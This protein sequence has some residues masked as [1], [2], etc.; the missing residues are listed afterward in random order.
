MAAKLGDAAAEAAK[1]ALRM[2]SAAADAIAFMA[3]LGEELP[4]LES[5]LKTIKVIREKADTVKRNREELTALEERCTYITACV[6]EKHRR[7]PALETDVTPLKKCVEAVEA[8]A[9]L[10]GRS[11]RRGRLRRIFK[12]SDD[13]DEI[14]GLSA[15][16]DRL[17]GDLQLAGIAT[18]EGNIDNLRAFLKR[19]QESFGERLSRQPARLAKVPKGTPASKSWHVERCQVMKKAVEALTGD[20]GPRLVGLVGHS[21]SG[22]TTAASDIVRSTEVRDT[23]H[24][25]IVWLSVN[26]GAKKRL[27]SLMMQLARTVYEGIGGC[28]GCPPATSDDGVAYIRQKMESGHLG[29]GLKCLVVADNV[30]ENEVVLKLLDTGMWILL[31]TR[32]EELVKGAQGEAVGVNELSVSDAKSVLRRAAE[33]SPEEDLPNEAVDLITLCGRVAMDLAF[34]GRWSTVRGRQDRKAWSDAA[35]KV[36]TEVN[37]VRTESGSD[38]VEGT[39]ARRRKAILRSGFEDLAVGSDDVRVPRLYLSLAVMPD[40]HAFTVKDAAVL[41]YDLAPSAEDTESVEAVLGTLER[42]TAVRL[43]EGTYHMHDAHSSFARE[44][45]VDRGDVR[46]PALERWVRYISSLDALR[47]TDP[48]VLKGLWLAVERVG[49]DGSDMSQ[50]YAAD[51]DGM[52]GSDPMLRQSIEAMGDFEEAQKDWEA[53]TNTWRRLLEVEK[54]ELG[55]DHSYVLNTFGALADCAERLGLVSKAAEWRKKGREA[56][57]LTLARMKLQLDGGR[58]DGPDD[59]CGLHSVGTHV[60]RWAPNLRA[61][62]ERLLRAHLLTQEA[63]LGRDGVEVAITLYSLGVCVRHAWRLDE[64]EGLLR[65]CLVIREAKLGPDDVRVATTLHELAVCVKDAGR[66]G[67]AEELLKRCLEIKKA[68]LCREH[69]G[70]ATTLH[71][72]GVCVRDAGRLEEAEDSLRCCLEIKEARLGREDVGVAYTLHELGKCVRD[73]GRSEEA[74]ELLRRCLAI[75]VAKLGPD[76]VEVAITLHELAVCVRG[77]GRLEEAEELLRCSLVMKKAKLG[78]DDVEVATT[79]HVL[80]VCVRDAGRPEEADKLLRRCVAIK[81]AKLGRETEGVAVTLHE[82]GVC[83]RSAGRLEEAE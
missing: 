28:V 21:G 38:G 8:F 60:S 16:V 32:D 54:R 49:G 69:V 7:L 14:A 34:V 1:R 75:E 50:P 72:L 12:A 70:V 44:G 76:V 5:V 18:V 40:G 71:E 30:W 36:R 20:G 17:T 79:L 10:C 52:D 27:P 78:R 47:S 35:Q 26:K 15:R 25:G 61:E 9:E 68:K 53:A 57:P 66:L 64:A 45:L 11:S 83:L 33:L 19:R 48:F 63:K 13:K 62:V 73:A 23:F 37:K 39:H 74:S 4:F 3:D 67:E 2:G 24:D 59:G 51:L 43:T 81:E 55:P 22:K 56:L 82:L 29:K 58:V 41:L 6:I 65:R 77:E 42:W 80:G 46:R 31:S